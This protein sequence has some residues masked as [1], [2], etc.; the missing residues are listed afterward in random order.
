MRTTTKWTRL[1]ALLAGLALIAAACGDDDDTA[2][3]DEG[4]DDTTAE[5]SDDAL[6]IGALLPESGSLSSIIGAL[7]TPI[8]LA[9][10]EINEAG[11]VLGSDVTVAAADDATDDSTQAQAGFD[12]LVNSEGIQVLLGPASSTLAEGLMDAIAN[13]DVVACSGSN[14]AA[15]LED[16]EDNGH[17]FGFAPNDNLQGPALAEVISSDGHSNVAILARNDTYG[18]G[19]ADAVA[20]A[21]QDAGINVVHNE[22]YDPEA[23]S[24]YQSDVEALVQ[25]DPDAAVIIGFSDDGGAIVSQMIEQGVGPDSL[26]I[27]TGDGMKGSSFW[28]TV[29]EDPSLVEGIKGTAPAA[30][31]AGV[32]HPFYDAYAETGEDTIFS[33]YFYDCAIASALAAQSADSLAADDI[34]DAMLEVTA[35]GT[36]CQTFAECKDLLDEGEDIDYQGASGDLTLND[37]GHVLSGAYDVWAYDAEGADTTLDEPQIVIDRTE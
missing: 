13:N 15:S 27:Y 36:E 32:E 7:R 33:A 11:G 22:T 19:F 23:T 4:S 28:E 17:Y 20:T 31:P 34:A 9:V 1:L 37:D 35:D 18:T 2:S 6:V 25:S 30:A 3:D 10:D 12:R 14:T 29:G 8:N 26:P 16:L 21:L 24:G 5:T